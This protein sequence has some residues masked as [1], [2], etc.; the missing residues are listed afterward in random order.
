MDGWTTTTHVVK[1]A[2]L[3]TP[4]GQKHVGVTLDHL[5]EESIKT[6]FAEVVRVC[7][8]VCMH[9]HGGGGGARHPD[10][11]LMDRPL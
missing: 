4:A 5:D 8:K 11:V 3:P 9:S 10:P 1:A 2:A 7:G 6:G